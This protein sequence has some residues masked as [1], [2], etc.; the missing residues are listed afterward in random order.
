M[1]RYRIF[2]PINTYD[3][4]ILK[5]TLSSFASAAS[6]NDNAYY[7]NTWNKNYLIIE[8][9]LNQVLLNKL[10]VHELSAD[11]FISR[12][13]IELV[14]IQ[15]ENAGN[16]LIVVR[17]K[18]HELLD[19]FSC[20]EQRIPI[21]LTSNSSTEQIDFYSSF[22]IVQPTTI[23]ETYKVGSVIPKYRALIIK[24]VLNESRQKMNDH[25]ISQLIDK[26]CQSKRYEVKI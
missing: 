16:D 1:S 2:E 5:A 14:N 11:G 9:P 12:A 7:I 19:G 6:N 17:I 10:L 18:I 4:D 23:T 25:I 20:H 22:N 8:T 15:Y 13:G 3:E 26:Y 24:N 21:V